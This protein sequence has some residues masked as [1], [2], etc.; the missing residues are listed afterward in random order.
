MWYMVHRRITIPMLKR[1][2]EQIIGGLSHPE[3]MPCASFGLPATECHIGSLL[4]DVAGSTCS[5]CYAL[6]GQY[7]FANV[8]GAQYCRLASLADPRWC[9]AMTTLIA[10][11]PHF[12]WHDSG[13]L[14]GM[15]HLQ[16]IVEVCK[17]TLETKHWLPTREHKLIADYLRIH[18]P[19][20][21]NLVVRLSAHLKDTIYPGFGGLPTSTVHTADP[22]PGVKVCHAPK[23][24]GHCGGC[25][26]CWDPRVSV[27][28]YHEH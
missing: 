4:R 1:D 12:R 14:M 26:A 20:P 7:R 21:S 3:K 18:G 27:V 25:R 2:A 5:N 6:K 17:R 8:Q 11:M 13:D 22:F 9:D 10:G 24:D 16:K 19:F 15:F 28:S 23:R